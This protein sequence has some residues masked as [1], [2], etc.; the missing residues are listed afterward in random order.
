M[1]A[2][3]LQARANHVE[4]IENEL[5][6]H[7]VK[8]IKGEAR[9][10]NGHS[11]VVGD[12]ILRSRYIVVGCGGSPKR[13]MIEGCDLAI[14]I[15]EILNVEEPGRILIAGGGAIA[16]ETA[17]ILNGLGFNVVMLLRGQLLGTFDQE[18]VDFYKGSLIE[19]GIT[20]K[21][22]SVSRLEKNG[23]VVVAVT[24]N[25]SAE[26]YD[27]VMFAM[28]VDV[29]L[30]G[31]RLD[32]EKAGIQTTSSG[33]IEVTEKMMTSA[34]NVYACGDIADGF[35]QL[36]TTALQCGKVAA[37]TMFKLEGQQGVLSDV[38]VVYGKIEVGKVVSIVQLANEQ[39]V[40]HRF[41]CI[42]SPSRSYKLKI[43]E[44]NGFV[45]EISCVGPNCAEFLAGFQAAINLNLHI[46]YFLKNDSYKSVEE[47][48]HSFLP[49]F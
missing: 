7:E 46:Q 16:C 13:P 31:K 30:L 35:S 28:G 41:E 21:Q 42:I 12:K 48:S 23:K 5:M 19:S 37:A 26:S 9:F 3:A 39:F 11:I 45:S 20:V 38:Q 33:R 15:A 40:V 27:Q 47:F 1:R 34:P 17:T 36:R 14:T 6:T 29:E 49:C 22:G 4:E 10:F 44:S 2:K 18:L 32:L 8:V 25:G 24:S 43:C